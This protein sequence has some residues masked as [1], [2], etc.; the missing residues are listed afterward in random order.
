MNRRFCSKESVDVMQEYVLF[1]P[2]GTTD[3][4]GIN[5]E[6]ATDG[7]MIRICRIY[8]PK[9]VYLFYSKEMA[10]LKENDIAS[11]GYDRYNH[12]LDRLCEDTGVCI[13]REEWID[14]NCEEVQI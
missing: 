2:V 8:R 3:P 10:E 12:C 4:M 9:K 11:V 6:I 14:K 5:K 1:S 13:D 7:P